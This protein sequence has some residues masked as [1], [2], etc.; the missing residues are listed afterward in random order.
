LNQ[1]APSSP[2]RRRRLLGA[3]AAAV[4]GLVLASGLAAAPAS[5]ATAGA[6]ASQGGC[7]TYTVNAAS[8]FDIGVCINDQGTNT[9]AYPD[10]Y[11]NSAGNTASCGI[12]ISVWDGSNHRLSATE[13]SC[14]K[15]HYKG[16]SATPSSSA[17]VHTFAR[18]DYSGKSGIAVGNSPSINVGP[19]G[20]TTVEKHGDVTFDISKIVDP[21]QV[22]V[23]GHCR[24]EIKGAFQIQQFAGGASYIRAARIDLN[25]CLRE[26]IA[27]GVIV[28]APLASFILQ[29]LPPGIPGVT[30]ANFIADYIASISSQA[31][32]FAGCGAWGYIFIRIVPPG[33]PYASCGVNDWPR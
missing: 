30:I 7:S 9:T 6:Q 25:Q 24:A 29:L 4:T 23:V 12:N 28:G 14:K 8:G 33:L 21:S 22:P 31:E 26:H 3:A 32:A 17:T 20:S 2:P 11:V 13:V 18:I 15:G 16:A 5:A 19:A 1:I 27:V 10:I